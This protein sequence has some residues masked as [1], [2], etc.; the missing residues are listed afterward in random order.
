MNKI[1]PHSDD[2]IL[3][4]SAVAHIQ[5]DIAEIKIDLKSFINSADK[6]FATK[7]EMEKAQEE[8][9]WQRRTII[10]GTVVFI[11]AILAN[12]VFTAWLAN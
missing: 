6:K 8:I 5:K 2:V 9:I 1:C 4:K 11:V 10:F 7:E 3:T 12:M